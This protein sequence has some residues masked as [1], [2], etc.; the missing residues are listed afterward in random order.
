MYLSG[1]SLHQY[2]LLLIGYQAFYK[3]A[4]TKLSLAQ[5]WFPLPPHKNH[6]QS[7]SQLVSNVATATLLFSFQLQFFNKSWLAFAI[8][9]RVYFLCICTFAFEFFILFFNNL[10]IIMIITRSCHKFFPR[11]FVSSF[12]S[13]S[14]CIIKCIVISLLIILSFARVPD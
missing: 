10:F 3:T 6:T 7:M 2:A 13:A 14:M 9:F 4:P 5:K 8:F 1:K 11:G 12:F